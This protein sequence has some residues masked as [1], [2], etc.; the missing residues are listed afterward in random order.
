MPSSRDQN[1]VCLCGHLRAEHGGKLGLG[2]CIG[3]DCSPGHSIHSHHTICGCTR[4]KLGQIA[5]PW[6]K[7]AEV[8][9]A[10][11]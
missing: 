7:D 3:L 1:D 6:A 10:A 5:E 2:G 4:F 8:I 11:E 9:H